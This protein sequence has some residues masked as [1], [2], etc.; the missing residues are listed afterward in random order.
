MRRIVSG[1]RYGFA[2]RFAD[3]LFFPQPDWTLTEKKVRSFEQ[4]FDKIRNKNNTGGVE[5]RNQYPKWELLQYLA[6]HKGLFLHGSNRMD[7]N[8][9][10][11][12]E[13][14]DFSGMEVKAVF[15]TRDSIWAI[16]FAIVDMQVYRGSLRNACWEIRDAGGKVRRYYFF[17]LNREILV[18][19]PWTE[20]MVYFLPGETFRPALTGM[21]RFDEWLS[22]DSVKPVA[23]LCVSPRD[24]PFKGNIAGH[25]EGESMI[26]SWMLYK[27]RLKRASEVISA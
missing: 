4:F 25:R 18:E 16:F 5:Y 19:Q 7:I 13:Q 12:R 26:K 27:Y 15:A 11:P 6:D 22:V 9:L 3:V 10:L 20:G 1:I 2:V 8:E 21:V 24:F 14:T 23:S 17:S